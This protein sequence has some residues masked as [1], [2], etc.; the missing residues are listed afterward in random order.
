MKPSG[1]NRPFD[2]H[3]YLRRGRPIELQ[4]PRCP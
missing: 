2:L 1:T 3:T 4:V